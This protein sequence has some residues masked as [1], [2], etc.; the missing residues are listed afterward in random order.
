MTFRHIL[1]NYNKIADGL[2]NKAM[3]NWPTSFMPPSLLTSPFPKL[4][5]AVSRLTPAPACQPCP[6]PPSARPAPPPLPLSHKQSCGLRFL[7]NLKLHQVAHTDIPTLVAIPSKALRA[8]AR[9]YHFVLDNL[10]ARCWTEGDSFTYDDWHSAL[11]HAKR[12]KAMGPQGDRMDL[13]QQLTHLDDDLGRK[14]CARLLAV[15]HGH[16]HV[17]GPDSHDASARQEEAFAR[18]LHLL[19]VLLTANHVS[20]NTKAKE[21]SALIILNCERFQLMEWEALYQFHQDSAVA[22]TQAMA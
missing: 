8:V 16:N 17:G 9:C 7:L 1:R 4:T 11:M 21:I 10:T 3:D 22:R 19:P 15:T 5:P 12:R 18:L 20:A 6:T 13:L 2:C 14:L